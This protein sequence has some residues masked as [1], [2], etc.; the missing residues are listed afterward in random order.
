MN[1]LVLILELEDLALFSALNSV[2]SW[3]GV[4]GWGRT[5]SF[6]QSRFTLQWI[7]PSAVSTLWENKAW[8]TA[9]FL[10]AKM[11]PSFF[12]VSTLEC[13]QQAENLERQQYHDAYCPWVHWTGTRTTWGKTPLW[14][15][16][17]FSVSQHLQTCYLVSWSKDTWDCWTL[18]A[19]E[20]LCK[21]NFH[22]YV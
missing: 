19:P 16:S 18:I 21:V 4:S 7:S 20:F 14:C 11:P 22:V 2:W 13:G 3:L 8:P 10:I 9:G 1:R 12:R 6:P 5:G 17:A 15:R